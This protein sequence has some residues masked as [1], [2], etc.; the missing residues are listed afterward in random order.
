MDGQLS[1]AENRCNLLE[2]QLDYMRKMVQ[3]AE[4]DKV[5]TMRRT[6]LLQRTHDDSEE[7]AIKHQLRKIDELERDHLKLT[8]TQTL[9]EVRFS[10][11]FEFKCLF[12][13][14]HKVKP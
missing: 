7:A 11:T 3:G 6:A 10:I 1:A 14:L 12:F 8:A 9:A 13:N 2:K 4:Q 5:D